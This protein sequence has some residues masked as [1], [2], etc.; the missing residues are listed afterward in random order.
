MGAR[1]ALK[2]VLSICQRQPDR[3]E[4]RVDDARRALEDLE[5]R[6]AM[7][8]DQRLRLRRAAMV[9]GQLHRQVRS[10]GALEALRIRQEI[11]GASHPAY[12]TSLHNLA[13]LYGSMG[14]YARAEPLYRQA[15]EIRKKTLA[16]ATP[17][18]ATSLNNLAVLYRAMGDY[19][20]AEPLY[21]EALEIRKKPWARTTPTMPRA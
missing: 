21:R 14:D 8:P 5:R 4:W 13:E 2:E 7:T 11:L 12:A 1:N 10:R 9:R 3:K 6:A 16:R 19:A 15:L 20:R 17:N 18:Y